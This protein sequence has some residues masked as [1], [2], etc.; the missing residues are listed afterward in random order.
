MVWGEPG[1]GKS[2]WA[3]AHFKKG[4]YLLVTDIDDIRKY[5]HTK[6]KAIIMDDCD[7]WLLKLPRTKAL[8]WV[9]AKD[10]RSIRARYETIKISKG[11]K[12]IICTNEPLGNCLGR[13]VLQHGSI[14]RRIRL[15][16]MKGSYNPT[17]EEDM[18]EPIE[19]NDRVQGEEEAAEMRKAILKAQY[20][21]ATGFAGDGMPDGHPNNFYGNGDHRDHTRD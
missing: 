3:K 1:I 2:Q 14:Q 11:T 5:D 10:Q 12:R 9:D 18:G 16:E 19:L 15:R 13:K 7:D 6:H 4:E 8:N 21:D 20:A 17:L